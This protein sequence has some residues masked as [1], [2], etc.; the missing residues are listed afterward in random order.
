MTNRQAE[1]AHWS[2]AELDAYVSV[3]T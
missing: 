3:V 1:R 2:L